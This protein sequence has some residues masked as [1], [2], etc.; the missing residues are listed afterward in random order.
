[1]QRRNVKRKCPRRLVN[2]MSG[3]CSVHCRTADPAQ[4]SSFLLCSKETMP[5]KCGTM[6]RRKH[7]LNSPAGDAGG[8]PAGSPQ[9]ARDSRARDARS[10]NAA[11]RWSRASHEC[12]PWILS[13]YRSFFI[14]PLQSGPSRRRM[15]EARLYH[16]RGLDLGR[17]AAS[18]P[19]PEKT[20]DN[21]YPHCTTLPTCRS[22]NRA[23]TRAESTS[24]S[25]GLLLDSV[26]PL[27]ASIKSHD[28]VLSTDGD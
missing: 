2:D 3:P 17:A 21:W 13:S 8:D 16:R 20:G 4:R 1:M 27:F 15:I 26:C 9:N 5:A 28:E 14:L 18:N 22:V 23:D 19:L 7:C 10:L 25:A 6:R 24:G 11:G 12:D